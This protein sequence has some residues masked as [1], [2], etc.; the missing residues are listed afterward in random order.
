M[1]SGAELYCIP[2]DAAKKIL[3]QET[4]FAD[5]ESAIISQLGKGAERGTLRMCGIGDFRA[6][7][8]SGSFNFGAMAVLPCSMNTLGKIAN[9]AADNLLVRAAEVALKERRRLVVCPRETPPCAL[10]HREHEVAVSRGGDRD[11]RVPRVLR[12]AE[13]RPR[14][15][16]FHR[17]EGCG[18]DGL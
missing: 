1:E 2:T 8:A 17:G 18:G 14:P 16:G 3:A 6:P 10:A 5:F 11:A 7:P 4:P 12:E 13:I 15:R 9:S